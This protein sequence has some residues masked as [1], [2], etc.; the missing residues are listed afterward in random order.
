MYRRAINCLYYPEYCHAFENEGT[1]QW[2][3]QN[4]IIWTDPTN[5]V[6]L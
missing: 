5:I 2:N 6:F 1:L 4:A 3:G